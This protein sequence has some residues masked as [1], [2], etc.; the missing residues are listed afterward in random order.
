MGR[1]SGE[2][3]RR[4]KSSKTAQNT[5]EQLREAMQRFIA[6]DP[7]GAVQAL[8]R[9]ARG[10]DAI[11]AHGAGLFPEQKQPETV[12]VMSAFGPARAARLVALL[13]AG[14][15]AQARA[16]IAAESH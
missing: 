16:E 5:G 15:V 1:R 13:D 10:V 9:T 3:R 11:L 7:D 12:L 6:R 2:A 14:E 8:M 4:K